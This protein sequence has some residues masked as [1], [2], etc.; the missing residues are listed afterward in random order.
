MDPGGVLEWRDEQGRLH[1]DDG[2]AVIHAN[3][4]VTYYRDGVRHRDGAPACV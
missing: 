3:G 2:P 4:S 1:R